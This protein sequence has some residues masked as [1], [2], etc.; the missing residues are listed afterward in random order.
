MVELNIFS[1]G[2]PPDT[3]EH[4]KPVLKKSLDLLNS[5]NYTKTLASVVDSTNDPGTIQ[6][7]IFDIIYVKL[8]HF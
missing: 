4:L 7:R 6:V 3:V 5:S 8:V 2:N 1:I